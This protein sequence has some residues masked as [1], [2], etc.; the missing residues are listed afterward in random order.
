MKILDVIGV[1]IVFAAF[2]GFPVSIIC[3]KSS[4]KETDQVRYEAVE[5]GFAEWRVINARGK[6][7]FVWREEEGE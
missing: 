2:I 7:E 4:V 3:L 5:R 1:A 6:T